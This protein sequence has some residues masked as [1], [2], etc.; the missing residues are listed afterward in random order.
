[1]APGDASVRERPR[2]PRPRTNVQQEPGPLA[3][4]RD[5]DEREGEDTSSDRR[6]GTVWR[7][8]SA[9]APEM[10]R[11]LALKGQLAG[12]ED[13]AVAADADAV[14][15]DLGPQLGGPA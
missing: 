14:A 1:M 11:A 4:V 13:D 12:G 3:P 10:G 7:K 9:R 6:W 2:C 8:A 15:V 5:G